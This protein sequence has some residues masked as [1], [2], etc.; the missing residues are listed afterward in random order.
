MGSKA[1]LSC[2]K[3]NTYMVHL[4]GSI[5]RAQLS[6]TDRMTVLGYP[7]KRDF[8]MESDDIDVLGQN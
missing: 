6:M 1:I 4:P 5:L 3:S 2:C 8:E 7:Q